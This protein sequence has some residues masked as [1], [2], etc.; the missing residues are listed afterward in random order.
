MKSSKKSRTKSVQSRNTKR[1]EAGSAIPSEPPTHGLFEE[2]VAWHWDGLLQ[3]ALLDEHPRSLALYLNSQNIPGFRAAS[4]SWI[5]AIAVWATKHGGESW[6]QAI[7]FQ[8]QVDELLL[9]LCGSEDESKATLRAFS[10]RIAAAAKRGDTE[11]FVRLGMA[12]KPQKRRP[13]KKQTVGASGMTWLLITRWLHSGLWLMSSSDGSNALIALT[14]KR[15]GISEENYMK[16]CQRLGL[17]GWEVA[18]QKPLVL[19]YM[20]KTRRF[21]FAQGWE[22]MDEP[23]WTGPTPRLSR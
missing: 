18:H 16:T 2:K 21:R 12:I 17:V 10:D 3:L 7:T 8:Q 13:A 11:F 14:G 22:D 20:P 23:G 4:E 9:S 5:K 1:N 6:V 19:G 15:K